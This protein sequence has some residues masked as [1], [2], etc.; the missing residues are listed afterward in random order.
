MCQ[1][2]RSWCYRMPGR[3][4]SHA[5]NWTRVALSSG[6]GPLC[7]LSSSRL[8]PATCSPGRPSRISHLRARHFL[9]ASPGFPGCS[10]LFCPRSGVH[11][12]LYSLPQPIRGWCWG[13]P[14][15]GRGRELACWPGLGSECQSPRRSISRAG[16]GRISKNKEALAWSFVIKWMR[17]PSH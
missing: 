2:W 8:G 17:A 13:K 1:R 3:S 12:D 7:H 15:G 4:D 5:F 6:K 14:E 11:S 16:P 10:A 9:F